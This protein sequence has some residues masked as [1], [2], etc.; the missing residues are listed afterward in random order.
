MN[1]VTP[2]AATLASLTLA[3][4]SAHAS[5]RD[6]VV[7]RSGYDPGCGVAVERDRET[8]TMRWPLENGE[9]GQLVLDLRDGKPLFEN[10]AIAAKGGE[11]FRPV[12]QGVDPV[13]FVVVG[14]RR[15]PDGRPPEMSAF[16]VFFDSPANRPFQAHRSRLDLKRAGYSRT[17]AGP[18]WPWGSLRL[19][20]SLANGRSRSIR[21][22]GWSIWRRSS[23]PGKSGGLSSTT[24]AWRVNLLL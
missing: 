8:L 4:A 2:I 18:P 14:E 13:T 17:A 9:I 24:R 21:V 19:G 22:L 5:A 20:L 23:A 11:P 12:L 1:Q 16:N 10:I 3:L 6:V 7:D 15:S